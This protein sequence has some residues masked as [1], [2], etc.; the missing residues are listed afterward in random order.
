MREVILS[1]SYVMSR[2]QERSDSSRFQP[3]AKVRVRYGVI[4]PDLPDIPLG[5]WTGIIKQVE[6][7]EGETVYEIK[8]DRKTLK[9]VHPVYLRRCER[10]GF[11][12]EI[13]WLAE[14]DLE[15]DEGTLVPIEQPTT[16]VTPPLSVKDQDD[17]IRA[18]FGL[19]HDDLIPQVNPETLLIYF[20]Y[21]RATLTFPFPATYWDFGRLHD[22]KITVMI[23]GL[24]DPEE[25]G[26]D[27]EDG[28]ICHGRDHNG[29]IE[30]PLA[31]IELKK[32]APNH[33]P[34]SDYSYWFHNW[35]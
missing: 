10:D 11:D 21:L 12:A 15:P 1:E 8:W 16:I 25:I 30:I 17:R 27:E 29:S 26:L 32:K 34:V 18:V 14:E 9:N 24:P 20:R 19:T 6:R 5:G 35:R 2:P 33:E 13:M 23:H 28:L 4:V 31:E 7:S 22:Q 3:G